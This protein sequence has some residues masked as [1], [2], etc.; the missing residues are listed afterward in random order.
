MQIAHRHRLDPLALQSRDSAVEQG[1]VERCLDP[2]VGAHPLAHAEPQFAG[3]KLLGRRQAQIVAIVLQPLAH[4]DYIAMAFG[5]QQPD[6]GTPSLEQRVGRDRCAMDNAVGLGHQRRPV[7]AQRIGQQLQAVEDADRRISRGRGNFRQ[8]RPT[9]AVDRDQIGKG[10]ADIDAD[11][12][13]GL[14]LR[15]GIADEP[16]LY[17]ACRGIGVAQRR[18]APAS[19]AT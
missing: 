2:A 9:G 15:T 10:A 12:V 8:G 13:H 3:D 17:V 18:I 6:L 5:R 14:A 16:V 11:A 7:E 19:A 4:L 1:L